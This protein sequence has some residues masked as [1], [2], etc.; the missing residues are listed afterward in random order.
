[1]SL[2]FCYTAGR[3]KEEKELIAEIKGAEKV[4]NLADNQ[5]VSSTKV[6]FDHNL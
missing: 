6:L 2:F 1:M 4:S 3:C 5:K